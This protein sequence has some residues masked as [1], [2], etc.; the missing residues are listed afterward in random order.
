LLLRHCAINTTNI[1]LPK[2]YLQV[3]IFSI[4]DYRFYFPK[5]K[6]NPIKVLA[7][8]LTKKIFKVYQKMPVTPGK[9]KLWF[10]SKDDEVFIRTG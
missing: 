7:L 6:I 4:F 3:A 1:L 5:P 9:A 10:S 2:P 8:K